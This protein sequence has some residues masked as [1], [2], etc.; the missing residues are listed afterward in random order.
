M[1]DEEFDMYWV[2]ESKVLGS[3]N[4]MRIGMAKTIEYWKSQ[5]R[6]SSLFWMELTEQKASNIWYFVVPSN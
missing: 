3:W 6:G 5:E 1:K 2:E 4:I